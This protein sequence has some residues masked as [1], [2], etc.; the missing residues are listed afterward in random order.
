MKL[1]DTFVINGSAKTVGWV[2]LILRRMQTG[3]LYTYAFAM[4]VGLCGL[5]LI[6]VYPLK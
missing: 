5:L 4:I 1:I 3:Y 6:F 2:S